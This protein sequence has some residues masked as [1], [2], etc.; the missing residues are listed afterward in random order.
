MET[1]NHNFYKEK[2]NRLLQDHI[3]DNMEKILRDISTCDFSMFL[4]YLSTEEKLELAAVYMLSTDMHYQL[5]FLTEPKNSHLFPFFIG[6]AMM[7]LMSQSKKN[8]ADAT[9]TAINYIGNEIFDYC[10]HSLEELLEM[11]YDDYAS[12]YREMRIAENRMSL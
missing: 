11:I 1:S 3:V 5:E 7:N 4:D 12:E 8:A 6:T 2:L 9:V 10:Q